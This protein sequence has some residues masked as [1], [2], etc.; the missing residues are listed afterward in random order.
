M[1]CREDFFK[2]ISVSVCRYSRYLVFCGRS[3]SSSRHD[4]ALIMDHFWFGDWFIL[5]QLAKN[6]H[7]E[8]F[9]DLVVD[10]KDR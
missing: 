3:K 4:V 8:V 6:M 7:P 5:M 2:F 10:L 1:S 9:H